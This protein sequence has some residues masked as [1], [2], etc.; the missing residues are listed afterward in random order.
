MNAERFARADRSDIALER[1][2]RIGF[3]LVWHGLFV[4]TITN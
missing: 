4:R 2:K 3:A 1:R